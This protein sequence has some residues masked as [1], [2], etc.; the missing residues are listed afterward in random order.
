VSI[1]YSKL[2]SDALLHVR[3]PDATRFLQGQTTCDVTAVDPA[4]ARLGAYCTPQGRVIC[5]FLLVQPGEEH[6][7]LRMRRSIRE[8]AATA[9]GKYI[10]FSRAELESNREDW[11]VWAVWG[12]GAMQ[13]LQQVFPA[14]PETELGCAA[15]DAVMVGDDAEAD[16]EWLQRVV[17]E[18][19]R[20]PRSPAGRQQRR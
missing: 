18:L 11:Q 17:L 12:D 9:F 14:A 15:G 8:H 19:R 3:G 1:Y 2:E 7:A 4:H 20:R 6:Y 5:D 10:V 13:G 16:I